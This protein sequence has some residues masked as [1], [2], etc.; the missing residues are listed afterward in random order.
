MMS[1]LTRAQFMVDCSFNAK[2]SKAILFSMFPWAS[3]CHGHFWTYR[4]NLFLGNVVTWN[5]RKHLFEREKIT[6]SIQ[7]LLFWLPLSFFVNNLIRNSI[8]YCQRK[9]LITLASGNNLFEKRINERLFVLTFLHLCIS[10]IILGFL[11]GWKG[12]EMLGLNSST[13]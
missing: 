1:S 11:S 6:R 7:F 9:S 12:V 4:E 10:W 2:Y 3:F 8:P 13:C 5:L